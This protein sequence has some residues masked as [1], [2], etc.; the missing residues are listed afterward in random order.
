MTND[1]IT[2]WAAAPHF[3]F[4]ALLLFRHSDFVIRISRVHQ[5]NVSR[6]APLLLL[7]LLIL[8]ACQATPE[9]FARG[10]EFCILGRFDIDHTGTFKYADRNRVRDLIVERGG[11]I[12]PELTSGT[13]YVIAGEVPALPA[14]LDATEKDPQ[15]IAQHAAATREYH[16]YRMTVDRARQHGVAVLEQNEF[17]K[18]IGYRPQ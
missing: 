4:G 9:S 15:K 16:R 17:L 2:D 7:L 6:A 5:P 11:R 8:P 12:A 18:R 1:R 14:G 13:D 10:R 3:G